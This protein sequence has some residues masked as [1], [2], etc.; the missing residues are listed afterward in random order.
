MCVWEPD[1]SCEYACD[2]IGS[3]EG[4]DTGYVFSPFATQPR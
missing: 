3:D 4:F 1:E 2:Y